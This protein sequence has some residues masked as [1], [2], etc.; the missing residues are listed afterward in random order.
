M[1]F[2][3]CGYKIMEK[4]KSVSTLFKNIKPTTIAI[5]V[6]PVILL[7]SL[8]V[9]ASF[10]GFIASSDIEATNIDGEL[11]S[12]A[13]YR[14][15]IQ[16]IEFFTTTCTTCKKITAAVASYHA[17][18]DFSDVLFWSISIDTINDQPH[19]IQNYIND[20]GLSDYV[21]EG[22]WI[23]ARDSKD[24]QSYFNIPG[25][26]T[27]FLMAQNGS[28]INIGNNSQSEETWRVGEITYE[29]I[30]VMIESLR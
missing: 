22:T 4:D 5:F 21:N 14:G 27:S 8:L 10:D 13:D 11:A 25:V 18:Y 6:I 7:G 26:P 24:Y 23:F 1:Y 16:F 2:T 12:T 30:E 9:F 20:H 29:E 19:I 3:I 28:F 15:K 17:S